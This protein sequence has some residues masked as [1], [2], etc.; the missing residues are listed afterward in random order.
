MSMR[1]LLP[2][3]RVARNVRP[4]VTR[5][6]WNEI[7][8]GFQWVLIGVWWWDNNLQKGLSFD[9][10]FKT[11]FSIAHFVV[12]RVHS[13]VEG[14]QL[15]AHE[16]TTSRRACSL[17]RSLAESRWGFLSRTLCSLTSYAMTL[18][19]SWRSWQCDEY[20]V[21]GN[22]MYIFS[23]KRNRAGLLSYLHLQAQ[24]TSP[25]GSCEVMHEFQ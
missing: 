4:G 13:I 19:W 3:Q 20:N 12:D 18:T 14:V 1:M 7:S 5:Y 6:C 15:F 2:F 8:A 25:H 17:L 11:P 21:C 22:V 23:Q 16:L 10:T 9:E 24:V